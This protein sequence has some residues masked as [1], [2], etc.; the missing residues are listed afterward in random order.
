MGHHANI[1][2]E[3]FPKQ[4]G[5]LGKR[6]SVSFHAPGRDVNRELP[7]EVVRDDVEE[8]HR[9]VIKL[10]DGRYVLATECAYRHV[11]GDLVWRDRR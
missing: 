5:F 11:R 2:H 4:G 10:D 6:V 8:P 3:R 9:T 1:G 7:G